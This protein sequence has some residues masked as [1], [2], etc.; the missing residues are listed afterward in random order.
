MLKGKVNKQDLHDVIQLLLFFF[1]SENF[2]GTV[3]HLV[4][5][6]AES[7]S[8]KERREM[9]IISMI[10]KTTQWIFWFDW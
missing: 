8:K 5:K 1:N 7:C 6:A 9:I 3:L 4:Q 10:S 2:L